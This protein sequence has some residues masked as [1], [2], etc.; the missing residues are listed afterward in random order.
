MLAPDYGIR[1]VHPE[2]ATAHRLIGDSSYQTQVRHRFFCA[3]LGII[4][5]TLPIRQQT[6]VRSIPDSPSCQTGSD[7]SSTPAGGGRDCNDLKESPQMKR[8]FDSKLAFFA[9]ACFFTLGL[10]WNVLHGADVLPATHSLMGGDGAQI[11]SPQPCDEGTCDVATAVKHGP[12]NCPPP[13]TDCV[14]PSQQV[15]A[16]AK[17]GPQNCPPPYTD[18]MVALYDG[19]AVSGPARTR[20]LSNPG[21]VRRFGSVAEFRRP[22]NQPR[23]LRS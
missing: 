4:H 22:E 7:W 17:H 18:C 13:Y 9:I 14:E 1:R 21:L 15:S 16:T 10:S 11:G 8:F 20:D 2:I 6:S 5:V 3:T 12:Q 23:Q 19:S